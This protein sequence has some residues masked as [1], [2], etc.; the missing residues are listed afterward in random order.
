[1]KL[2]E[3]VG[4]A[5]TNA[6]GKD[7]L[8]ELRASIQNAKFVSLSD[9]I[10]RELDE[11]GLSHEREN[12]RAL[13]GEWRSQEG[14]GVLADKTIALYE[15]EKVEKGYNGLTLTSIRQPKEVE[16]IQA[17]GGIVIWID[18]DPHVRYERTQKRGL[19]RPEDKKTFEQ[20]VAEEEA[21]MRPSPE[22]GLLDMGGVRDAADITIINEFDSVEQYEDY[23]KKEFEL[24]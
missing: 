24:A 5:G 18:A 3:I 12:L 21:E 23:L 1:M 8:G 17:A 4:V 6:S 20:F 15:S 11:R 7:T 9:I 19:N 2:P 16:V 14:L 13:G 22:N 10:R